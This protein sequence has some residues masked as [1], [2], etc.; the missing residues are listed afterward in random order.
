MIQ[1]V[2]RAFLLRSGAL[3]FRFRRYLFPVFVVILFFFT[4]PALFLGS[5]NL[6]VLIVMIG[7][8]MALA[9]LGFRLF[10]IGFAYIK[11]GGKEGKVY[12]DNLVVEG[13][14]AHVRNPMYIGN[15]FIIVGLG[16]IHGSL[17]VYIFLI[18]FS[19]FAY[20]SIVVTEEEYLRNRFGAEYDAY[21][22]N[23]NRFIPDFSG[24]RQTLN[25]FTYDWKKALRKE[26]GT[27]L[28]G[29]I[30][31]Y[32]TGLR[33]MYLCYGLNL[34]AHK[35]LLIIVPIIFIGIAYGV[36]RYFKKKGKLKS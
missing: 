19:T 20:L 23:V 4:R 33:K 17:W 31:C 28:G 10:V 11:R 27:S 22:A 26:Y 7:W 13:L 30:G 36:V 29:L 15:F 12:A 6:D 8:I 24:I 9:G 16:L 3:F 14:Y 34:S 21:C 35:L 18:P 2:G 5:R 25:T 32:A 1:R